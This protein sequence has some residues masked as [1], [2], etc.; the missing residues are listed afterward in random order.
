MNNRYVFE[1]FVKAEKYRLSLGLGD[2]VLEPMPLGCGENG[3]VYKARLNDAEV[4][5]K[6]F[7][8]GERNSRQDCLDNFKKEFFSVSLLET[9]RNIVQYIDYDVLEVKGEQIPV[10][11]MKLY[12]GSLK[13][14]CSSLSPE[15]F[16]KL[17]RFLTDSVQFLHS[18]GL[19]HRNIKPQNILVDNHNEFVLTDVAIGNPEKAINDDI[20][21]IGEVLKWYALGDVKADVQISNV[22]PGLKMYDEVVERC[23]LPDNE[24]RFHT[25]DEILAYVEMQ[26]ERDPKELMQEFSLICRKN[27]PK[28]LPEFVHCTDHKKMAKLFSNFTQK[29]DFFGNHIIYFTDVERKVFSPQ[30]GKNG[31]Y[32]LDNAT[33]IKI[34]DIW[35]HC[36]YSM[37]NDYILIHHAN[38]LPE[39]VN[40]KDSYK[41]A[42]YDKKMIITWTEAMNGYAEI[43]GDIIALD[44]TKIEFFNRIPREGYIFIALNQLHSLT[45][46]ANIGTLRDYFFRFSFNYVNRNILEDM[47]NLARQHLAAV[48]G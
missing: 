2:F 18:M 38:T 29:M 27:F 24:N 9:R 40:G 35:I 41:W 28:E 3:I 33:E 11:V 8:F 10:L 16:V 23:M 6:F 25:I 26:K 42:I 32:K 19:S 13:D 36:D 45:F 12:K 43:D 47:N 14:Y 17:F 46:P 44:K 48:K 39:K 30:I 4:A 1:E 37:Q 31:F 15:V 20:Y 5:L 22:F 34:L 7:L 21:A